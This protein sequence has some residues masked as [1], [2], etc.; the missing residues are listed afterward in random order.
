MPILPAAPMCFPEALFTESDVDAVERCWWVLHTRPRQE[1]KLAQYLRGQGVPYFFPL[2]R[3]RL[4]VR[5]VSRHSYLPLFSSYL[6]LQANEDERVVA[7]SSRRIVQVL[8]VA[9]QERL[10]NDLRQIHQLIEAGLSV[11]PEKT[12][13]PGS[14]V[15]IISG[16][17]SGLRGQVIRTAA[18]QRFLVRVDFI[19]QGASVL[20]D[21]SALVALHARAEH[22]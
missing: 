19:Q 1:K 22:N 15:E 18:G 13:L 10:D 20:L 17:L 11:T 14:P 5:G 16:P 7:L 12:L 4:L 3:K 8:P 9:E 6:F 2:T 21:G